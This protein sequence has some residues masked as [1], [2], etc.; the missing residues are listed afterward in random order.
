MRG[1]IIG[2]LIVIP[3]WVLAYFVAKT[4][5]EMAGAL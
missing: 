3:L 2:L 4:L 1:I 5:G